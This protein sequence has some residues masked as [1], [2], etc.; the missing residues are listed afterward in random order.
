MAR[1][2]LNIFGV[3]FLDLLSGALGAV[4]ILYII[5]PKMSHDEQETLKTLEELQV[6]ATEVQSM[7]EKLENSVDKAV[8]KELQEQI[9]SMQ[10]QIVILTEQVKE[11]QIQ[12]KEAKEKLAVCEENLEKL[13]N[14]QA[15]L[16]KVQQ[17]LQQTQ[18]DLA[19]EKRKREECENRP[20]CPPDYTEY[21]NWMQTCGLTP[22]DDCPRSAPNV[23]VGFKFKGKKIVFLIDVSGSMA[24]DDKIG[25]VKAGLKML[26][27]TMGPEFSIDMV[28]YPDGE[29][30]DYKAYF[31]S[32]RPMSNSNKSSIFRYLN[33][34]EPDQGTPTRA[35]L[36]FALNNY[37]TATD[38]VL[39]SDGIPTLSASVGDED[40]IYDIIN[41]ITRLNGGRANISCIGVGP[42]FIT[43]PNENKVKFLHQLADRNNGFFVGF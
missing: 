3:S 23:D 28:Q 5:I 22:Q 11:M 19:E 16:E 1:K 20:G 33:T 7:I 27:T 24:D 6:Q 30:T 25:Q 32:L 8:F 10:D 35:T 40:N 39:L 43:D 21:Y 12:L 17:Q 2:E 31:G 15:T 42:E 13:K 34:L 36:K 29:Y 14:V 41:E 38:Y 4:I 18:A 26:V 9:K 37:R